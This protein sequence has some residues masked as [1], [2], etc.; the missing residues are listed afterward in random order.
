MV[1]IPMRGTYTHHSSSVAGEE[2][3]FFR[4]APA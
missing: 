2:I 4:Y 1:T 3:Y